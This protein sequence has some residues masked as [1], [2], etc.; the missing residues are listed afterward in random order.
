MKRFL[1]LG[2]VA[3]A[4]LAGPSSASAASSQFAPCGPNGLICATLNV[5]VDYPGATLGQI[6]LYVEQ[7][8]AVGTPR[9]VML[10]LAGGPG[11]ASAE[12]F[13]LGRKAAYWRSFFPG[14]TLVA[15][16]DRG[17]GKSGALACPTARTVGQCGTAIGNRTYYTTRDHA[18][19]I[20]AVRLALGVNT[21]A[22]F[23]VSYGT[24]HAVAYALAHADHVERL[25]LDSEVLP[26]RDPL[27]TESLLTITPSVDGICVYNSCPGVTSGSGARLAALANGYQDKPLSA[28]VHFAPT[29]APFPMTIDGLELLSIAYESDLSSSVSSQLPAA[30][31]AATAGNLIPLQRLL[32]LDAVSNASSQNDI[33]I[34]LLLATNCGDGPFPWLPGDSAPQ[35]QAA[36]DATIAAL[37]PGS[38]GPYGLWALQTSTAALC[39]DWPSPA[40]GAALAP[41]PLPN[42]PVLVLAGSRDIRTPA[43]N[44]TAIAAR[45]PQAKVVV[46]PGAGHSVLNHSACAADAVRRWL[47]GATPPATCTPFHLYVPALGL[48]RASVAATP[49]APR[50]AGLP[51]RTLAVFLQTIHEAEDIWLLARKQ[52]V[53]M[54]GQISG[55]VTPFPTGQLKFEAYSSVRGLALTGTVKLK[56][57]PYG[58]PVVP[59]S[60]A[61]GTLTLT[62]RGS[63]HGTLRLAGNRAIGAVGGRKVTITF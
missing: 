52:Q 38:T 53:T 4:L 31:A 18:E 8:P 60:A 50:I 34:A 13:D 15:Y 59:L 42:V 16:D 20:E 55:R 40:G 61:S 9:G 41:G 39:I 22:L 19:D 36:L 5:P 28:T 56:L 30:V 43:S 44:A 10:L 51:G 24:K 25:L 12:T 49:P 63:S 35:R 54:S 14:Y 11:Q 23:G 58:D 32:Y 2:A 26:E 7:L 6:P 29:L 33:N 27:G 62:G 57:D 45:F 46:V 3:A 48:W 47:G 37:A 17:T 1:A 21:V